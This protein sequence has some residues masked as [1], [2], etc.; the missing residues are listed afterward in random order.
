MTN[1]LMKCIT[2]STN[3]TELKVKALKELIEFLESAKFGLEQWAEK[4]LEYNYSSE[5]QDYEN[6]IKK[7]KTELDRIY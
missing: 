6:E 4:D 1:S 2:D 3:A 7:V 5:V